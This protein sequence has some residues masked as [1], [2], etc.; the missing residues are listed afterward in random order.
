MI[1][2]LF[3]VWPADGRR[4][5]YLQ[6]AAL[7]RDELAS[8][9]GFI[10]VERFESLSEPGKLLSMSFW[11][12]ED[13]VARW[14]AHSRHRATQAAGRGGIFR[15]YRLRVAAVLRDYGLNEREQAPADSRAAHDECPLRKTPA[16]L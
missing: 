7:L 13:A 10:S 8:V 16:I 4:E 11:R 6:H 2:V 1:A 3:E 5:H 12:D 14:R 9:D 15:D